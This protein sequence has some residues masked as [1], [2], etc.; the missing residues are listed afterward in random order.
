MLVQPAWTRTE[1]DVRT[2]G[3][4]V[5]SWRTRPSWIRTTMEGGM[6]ATTIRTTTGYRIGW[7]IANSFGIPT[8]RIAIGMAGAMLVTRIST[9][10]WWKIPWTTVPGTDKSCGLTFITLQ[11]WR[12]IR[13]AFPRMIRTGLF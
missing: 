9:G 4:T 10:I 12:L 7:T 8:K 6:P 3:T 1:M 11:R 2:I 5:R 13:R